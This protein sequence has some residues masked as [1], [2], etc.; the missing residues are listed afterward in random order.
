MCASREVHFRFARAFVVMRQGVIRR[1]STAHNRADGC[2]VRSQAG[3]H[4]IEVAVAI[5]SSGK[6]IIN[7]IEFRV[8]IVQNLWLGKASFFRVRIHS[9]ACYLGVDLARLRRVALSIG[10]PVEDILVTESEIE[11]NLA[12]VLLIGIDRMARE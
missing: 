11:D 10:P 1:I 7:A 8:S 9:K 2:K 6:P 3:V 5:F 4:E 12:V